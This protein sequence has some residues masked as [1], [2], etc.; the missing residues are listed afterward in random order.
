M[1]GGQSCLVLDRGHLV[2]GGLGRDHGKFCTPAELCARVSRK[3]LLNMFVIM[4][5]LVMGSKRGRNE[6]KEKKKG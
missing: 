5:A 2:P 1:E 3:M 4:R 6:G